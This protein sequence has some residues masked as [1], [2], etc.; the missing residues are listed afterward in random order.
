M[1]CFQQVFNFLVH[2][3]SLSFILFNTTYT[4][5]VVRFHS[6]PGVELR[7]PLAKL[8]VCALALVSIVHTVHVHMSRS[9]SCVEKHILTFHLV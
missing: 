2:P 6:R 1:P 9:D 5:V 4:V 3:L 8:I 7:P